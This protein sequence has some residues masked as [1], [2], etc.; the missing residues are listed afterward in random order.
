LLGVV[1]I[2]LECFKKFH[3]VGVKLNY[4]ESRKSNKKEYFGSCV[5]VYFSHSF[6][7]FSFVMF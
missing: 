4:L 7:Y 5:L 1:I 3:L 2:S 6:V